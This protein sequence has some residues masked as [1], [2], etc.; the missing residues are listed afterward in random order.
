MLLADIVIETL[1][2]MRERAAEL[3]RHPEE[4][5]RV[6]DEGREAAS[7]VA[8]ATMPRCGPEWVYG[9]R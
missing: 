5:R 2:P 3:R 7:A 9:R 1:R 4:L 8:A 6:L